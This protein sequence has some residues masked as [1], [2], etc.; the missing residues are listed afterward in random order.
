MNLEMKFPS[1]QEWKLFIQEAVRETVGEL[2][3]ENQSERCYS[4]DELSALVGGLS[5][6]T[7]DK[8]RREGNLKSTKIR[9]RVFFR[10]SKVREWLDTYTEQ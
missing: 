4:K 2:I 3:K 8:E 7:I 1:S 5:E 9:G 10:D 6:Q